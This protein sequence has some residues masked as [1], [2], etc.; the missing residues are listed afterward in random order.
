MTDI[1]AAYSDLAHRLSELSTLTEIEGLLHWDQEVCMPDGA[2]GAR[3]RQMATIGVVRHERATSDDLGKLLTELDA[4][5]ALKP[6]ERANVREARRAYDLAKGLP[7][8]LVHQWGEATVKAHGSWVAARAASDFSLF[9]DDLQHLVD[10]ARAKA[11]AIDP[12]RPTY[13]VLIDNFEPGMTMDRLDEVFAEL[14]DFLVPFLAKIRA[15]PQIDTTSIAGDVAEDDQETVAKA[16]A[17]ALGY[18][19][20]YGRIDT[21]VHP[22]C[23]GAGATDV[24]ITTRYLRDQF[25]QSLLAVVHETG[26]AMYEQGRTRELADQPVSFARSMGVHESQS[27]LWETQ[28]ARSHAFWRGRL[29]WLKEQY[30]FLAGVDL[31]TFVAAINAVDFT[32]AIRVNA[33][34]VTYP[35]HVI[36]RYELERDLLSG[37]LAVRDLPA[38]WNERMEAWF[39]FVPTDDA[40]GVLQD[41]H[42][43]MG[44]FGY[45]PSY[46]LG[47]LYAAQIFAAA[48]RALPGLDAQ[49]ANGDFKQLRA[50][51]REHIH[52]HGSRWST[53]ELIER[54]TGSTL[55]LTWFI[56]H[57]ERR[58][59]ALYGLST[60][61][62]ATAG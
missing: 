46:T 62:A 53:D 13:D 4:H 10:L 50:W 31:E 30:T 26:H 45:F 41:I 14:R 49:L 19:L 48:G 17:E 20:Q 43:S 40:Q 55:D 38:A 3:G 9:A 54:A 28:V 25:H 33:D 61:S 29:P 5:A 6:I 24:R 34:E 21:A 56:Q 8:A 27:L 15:R 16:L 44:A 36:L 12:T 2:T 18:D 39:G 37:A 52:Q 57:I 47:A 11:K 22:F 7:A 58:Y 1:H 23:G 60:G 59:G 51:L 35:L 32:N 42:W